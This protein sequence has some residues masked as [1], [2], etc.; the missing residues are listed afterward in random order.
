MPRGQLIVF[1]GAEGAGKSTQLRLVAEW[2]GAH[3]VAATRVVSVR[4]PGG[5]VVGDEIRRL[6]LDPASD[7]VARTEAFLFMASRAQLVEREIRPAL[8]AG[9]TVLV[10]RFFLSTYAYQG[11]RSRA[12]RGGAPR[13]QS[14]GDGRVGPRLH[15][16]PR[17]AGRGRSGA[18]D[19]PRRPRP[20]GARGTGVPRTRGSGLRGVYGGRSGRTRTPSVDPI[21]LVDA[22]GDQ[23]GG[24]R[25]GARGAARS[26]A[27]D[28]PFVT[29]SAVRSVWRRNAPWEFTCGHVHYSPASC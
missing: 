9:A 1:E 26:L 7:I 28:F 17:A 29:R 23:D 3:G 10:D 14:N 25:S 19:A 22:A 2:L 27:R 21:E 24:I 16:A 4:E 5:T 11:A 12:A 15:A 20:D 6:L 13:R 8:D 18:S